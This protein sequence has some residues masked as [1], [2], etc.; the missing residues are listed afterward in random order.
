MAA[1]MSE[2]ARAALR[3]R[4]ART[5]A[6]VAAVIKTE[7]KEDPREFFHELFGFDKTDKRALSSRGTRSSC[8][9]TTRRLWAT[10]QR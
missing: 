5:G 8:A 10:P 9:S 3:D 4:E 6:P 1:I 7:V 2:K